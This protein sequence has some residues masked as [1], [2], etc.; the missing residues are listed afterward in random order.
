MYLKYVGNELSSLRKRKNLTLEE[1]ANKIGIHKNTLC[2]YETNSNNMSLETLEKILDYYGIDELIF[3][4]GI[5][6]YNHYNNK[7]ME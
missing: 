2:K 5:R 4:K 3:F 1:L 6:E 7:E